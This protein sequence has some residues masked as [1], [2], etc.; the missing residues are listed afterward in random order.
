MH[1]NLFKDKS[2][3]FNALNGLFVDDLKIPVN[4]IDEKFLAP[5]DIITE[6]YNKNPKSFQLMEEV[7]PFGMI[8]DE[9]FENAQGLTLEEVKNIKKQQQDYD[10][11]LIFGV[12]LKSRESGLLPTRSQLADFTRAFNREFPHTP[13]VVVFR[14]DEGLDSYLSIANAQR[15]IYKQPWREGEKIGRVAMLRDIKINHPHVGH[16]KILENLVISRAGQYAINSFKDLYD[17]WQ[18]VFDVSILNKNFYQELSAW[19]DWAMEVVTFPVADLIDEEPSARKEKEKEQQ[20]QHLIR[21]LTR[22]LFVWF[23]KEKNLIP[24]EL[25]DIDCIKEKWFKEEWEKAIDQESIYYQAIL[26]NLFF[27]TLNQK[28]EQRAF[29]TDGQNQNATHLMRYQKYF[30]EPKEFIELVESAVPFMN[31]GLFECLDKPDGDKKGKQGGAKIKYID[32]FSDR[33]DNPL[34]VPGFLFFGKDNKGL[35]DILKA[36][37]FTIDENTPLEEDIALDPELLGRVFENLLASYNPETKTT[38]RKQTG[39]FYTPREIVSYMVDESL[40]AYLKNHLREHF[41]NHDSLDKHLQL[42]FEPNEDLDFGDENIKQII[43]KAL[44]KCKVLDPACGSG[45][46][47]MGVLQKMVHILHQLDPENIYWKETQK[48]K[49]QA[50]SA[51]EFEDNPNKSGRAEKLEEINNI[52]DENIN[53][54]DYARKLYLIENCIYGVDIQS[55]AVQISKLRFFISLMAHQKVNKDKDN[56]GIRPLPNLETKFVAANALIGLDKPVDMGLSNVKVTE[57][58]EDLKKVRHRSFLAKT[59]R[60]KNN[61][62]DEDKRLREAIAKQLTNAGLG[63]EVA[64]QLAKWNPYDQNAVSSFFDADWMFNMAK[65]DGGFDVVIGNPP[66]IQLQ[67]FRG[68]AIQKSLANSGFQTHH[69][70]GDIYCLFYEKGFDLLKNKGHLTFIT[71]NKWQRAGYGQPLRNFLFNKTA[72]EKIIDFKGTKIFESATVD[73]HIVLFEK[74]PVSLQQARGC[75]PTSKT[76]NNKQDFFDLPTDNDLFLMISKQEKQIKE[77]IEKVGVPLKN[78]DVSIKYG[79]KTGYNEAFI[80]DKAKRDELIAK[81]PKSE[82]IIKPILR[83]R[84]IKRYDT[85]FAN[86]WVILAKY[87]SHK[88]LEKSYPFIFKYLSKYKN[89]LE[90]RGQ[91][92]Y[93]G[94]GNKG[95]HHWLELDNNPT[96]DYLKNFKKEKVVYPET[97]HVA[98]F[99]FDDMKFYIDKTGFIMVGEHLK[100][101]SICLASKIVTYYYR[102]FLEGTELAGRGWQYNKHAMINLPIPKPSPETEKKAVELVDRMLALK[103]KHRVVE[104]EAEQ[105]QVEGEIQFLFE[106]ID[107]LN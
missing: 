92:R 91:C 55:I 41:Q 37:K 50:E 27:A 96:D 34:K 57:L 33:S 101:L 85:E 98:N 5:R 68:Q 99:V 103:K 90:K 56:F 23:V 104:N 71:S 52:F 3:L 58:E 69:A 20:A 81:D 54:P 53:Y 18:K 40:M 95:Q 86:K 11:I 100:Y 1:L 12:I 7:L 79:I 32:G 36:Y 67:K 4:V 59:P 84:D 19:Y 28:M 63:N 24:E 60:T 76:I 16:L 15:I 13:V 102:N 10:G 2:N 105:K 82:E 9:A 38:A 49:A 61:L 77:K 89:E 107:V 30:K 44:D 62:R 78:W 6:T 22:L 35:V 42:L 45:A 70:M 48:I 43:I 29:R 25:F 87:D 65:D 74:K 106:I 21:L 75:F 31:G 83:G 97:T 39:S 73:T 51:R 26:Q 46:F 47:P 94:I 66:Y 64:E 17:Y 80:I 72:I 14:Y 88:Y 93:G 8:D